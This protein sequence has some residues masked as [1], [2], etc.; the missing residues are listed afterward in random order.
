[1][2]YLVAALS[3]VMEHYQKGS[4]YL[5]LELA[6]TAENNIGKHMEDSICKLVVDKIQ[7][8]CQLVV[9]LG[10]NNWQNSKVSLLS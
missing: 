9:N 8:S 2:Q 7:G 5:A 6:R 3:T 4:R 1:M 10:L